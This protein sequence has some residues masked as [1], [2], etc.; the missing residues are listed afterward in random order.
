MQHQE[1]QDRLYRAHSV[2][3]GWH[4]S[5]RDILQAPSLL[6]AVTNCRYSMFTQA[7]VHFYCKSHTDMHIP[8]VRLK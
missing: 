1:A 2:A 6:S 3:W 5:L 7:M 8:F 4:F